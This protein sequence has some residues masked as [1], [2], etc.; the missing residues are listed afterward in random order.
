[1]V[2]TAIYFK[3]PGIYIQLLLAQAPSQYLEFYR[4]LDGSLRMEVLIVLLN[5][6]RA[7]SP[8]K[9]FLRFTIHLG[10]GI[11]LLFFL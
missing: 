9:D 3:S 10:H 2:S 6:L 1:M 4:Q 5:L 7:E 8:C 11:L